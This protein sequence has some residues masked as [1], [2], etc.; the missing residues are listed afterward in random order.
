MNIYQ[1]TRKELD[2]L[3]AEKPFRYILLE[4]QVFGV[5]KEHIFHI[6]I[7]LDTTLSAGR[8]IV[9]KGRSVGY[10]QNTGGEGIFKPR[11]AGVQGFSKDVYTT[12]LSQPDAILSFEGA[13]W[14]EI[15]RSMP[16]TDEHKVMFVG[17]DE[18]KTVSTEKS[19]KRSGRKSRK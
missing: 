5:A 16:F 14:E 11:S 9:D 8:K 15:V 18:A 7:P 1:L 2:E 3:K 13:T 6:A 4:S 10:W 19:S 12:I 17:E